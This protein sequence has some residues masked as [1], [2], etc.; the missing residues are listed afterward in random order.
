MAINQLQIPS[1]NINN[2][3]DQ[4]Q[5]STL[6][7]LGN[8]YQKAQEQQRQQQALASL[9]TDPQANMRTLLTSQDPT[10]A[11]AGL[12]LQQKSIEQQRAD[13]QN[14]QAQSNWQQQQA[15]RLAAEKRA[16]ET[17]EEDSPEGRTKKLVAAGL[18]P[19]DPAYAAHIASG[20]ALPSAIQQHVE[21]RAQTTFEQEQKYATREARLQAVKEGEL[22]INDPEI[23]RWV[24]LGGPIPDP[25]KNR[26]GL[27]QPMY[28]RDR[29]GVLHAYQLSATGVPVEPK[30]PEGQTVLG[31]GEIA[32]QKAQG[33]ATGKAT[34][35]AQVALPDVIRNLD[36][37]GDTIDKILA[38]PGKS[39]ALGR[40]SQLPDWMTTGTDIGDFRETV[41]QLAGEAMAQ[42]M[43]SLKGSGLGSVSDFEQKTMISAFVQASTAQ[44]EKQFNDSM[45]TAKK[46]LDKIREIARAKAKGDFSERPN[47]PRTGNKPDLNTLIPLK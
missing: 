14:A 10:L 18:D 47:A 24:G 33:A 39:A 45:A 28:T 32:Q 6:A 9:G 35:A 8:V 16:A 38:H 23:R 12:N 11:Q 25:A 4:S 42:T 37:T 29:E 3:V 20:A 41:K 7:N 46:S 34:G 2:T 43:Q 1:S 21:Q 30:L 17:F 13:A 19:K 22:D 27:G 26:L 15:I 36:Q 31:P 40:G 5:W 44:S